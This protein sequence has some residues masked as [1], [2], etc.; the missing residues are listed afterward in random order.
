[1][2]ISFGVMRLSAFGD[3]RL[4]AGAILQAL[5][6]TVTGAVGDWCY[7]LLSKGLIDRDVV[8]TGKIEV[9]WQECAPRLPDVLRERR[10]P[11]RP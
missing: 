9:R 6:S 2:V 10:V 7:A 8:L 1:M 3:P 5:A 4:M 11:A